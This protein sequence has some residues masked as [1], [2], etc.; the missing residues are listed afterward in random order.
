MNIPTAII[1]D[2]SMSCYILTL[3]SSCQFQ[4]TFCLLKETSKS[5]LGKTY[6]WLLTIVRSK[7]ITK[8][9]TYI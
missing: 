1:S 4:M 5:T 7:V 6:C 9:Y 8:I 3:F 2:Y